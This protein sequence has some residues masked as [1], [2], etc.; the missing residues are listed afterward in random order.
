MVIGYHVILGA[1]GFWLPN[2]PRGSWSTFVWA[3]QLRRFGPATKVE[4]RRSVAA[5]PHQHQLRVAA[6][7]ALKYPAVRF[8]RLQAQ[9]IVEG[10]E[11]LVQKLHLTVYACSILPEHV[12]LVLGRR[13]CDVEEVAE[14][15]K[16]AGTRR[17]NKLDINPMKPYRPPNGRLPSPWAE[18]GWYVFI[19]DLAHLR[20]AMEYV[21][22]NPE[23]A[24]LRR[25]RWGLVTPFE[26][27]FAV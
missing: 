25:Q 23:K 4:T 21:E 11:S 13:N 5:R 9:T 24:G 10:F 20:Q 1:H 18:G 8:T 7:N 12:H 26:R 6:K 27:D 17:L 16:R 2:D 22:L 14:M 19:D 15:L 3:K